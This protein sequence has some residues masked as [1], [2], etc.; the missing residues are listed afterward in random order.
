MFFSSS[1]LVPLPFVSIIYKIEKYETY[2]LPLFWH[3]NRVS[4]S[5]DFYVNF[6]WWYVVSYWL[7]CVL[8]EGVITPSNISSMVSLVCLEIFL[9]VSRCCNVWKITSIPILTP[10]FSSSTNKTP[11]KKITAKLLTSDAPIIFPRNLNEKNQFIAIH[12]DF[13]QKCVRLLCLWHKLQP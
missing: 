6:F 11:L 2:F 10:E 9:K 13:I 1:S 4:V 12:Q 7:E 5:N 3:R 8:G